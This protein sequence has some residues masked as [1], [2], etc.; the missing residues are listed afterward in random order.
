MKQ[1]AFLVMAILFTGAGCWG[2]PSAQDAQRVST[3]DRT[4]ILAEARENDLIMDEGEIA[5]MASA[6]RE[7]DSFGR[8]PGDL[9]TYLETNVKDWRSAALADVTGGEGFGIAQATFA[10]GTFTLIAEMGNLPEPSSEYFYEAWLVRREGELAV[11]SLGR[12]QKT[13]KGYTMVYLTSTDFSDHDFFVLTLELD[14]ANPAPA[15]HILEGT[16]K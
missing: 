6:T 16:L 4:S 11:F 5:A 10:Q 9:T 12:A 7:G 8:S 15:E 14:D 2:N 3:I 13:Q 1:L